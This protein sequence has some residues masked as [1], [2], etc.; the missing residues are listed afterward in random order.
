MNDFLQK[1][2]LENSTFNVF[3]DQLIAR[4]AVKSKTQYLRNKCLSHN[5]F[6]LFWM[7]F[8]II[9]IAIDDST[10]EYFEFEARFN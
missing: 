4:W 5:F 10:S 8:V 3:F 9:W 7:I 6:I 2:R 1:M